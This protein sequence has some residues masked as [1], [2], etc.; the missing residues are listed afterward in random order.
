VE[1][2]MKSVLILGAGFAGLELATALSEEVA[3][4]V[5]VTVIDQSD[6][7]VFGFSKLD[8]MFGRAEPRS[9][10]LAYS[11]LDKPAVAF[12][13][14]RVLSI[15]AANRRVT[16]DAGSYEPDIL[17]V[18]LGA[19][20]DPAATPGLLE[21]G[22]E[23]YSVSGA[24]RVRSILPDFPG[25]DVIISVLGPFF[26]CPAA[27]FE[28]ALMMH[29]YL[30]RRGRL[31]DSTIKVISPMAM[32]IPISPEASAGILKALEERD[33]GWWPQS[34][35]TT[36]DP[37][38]KTALLDDGRTTG[39]DLFL[40][41][42]VHR[43]PQVVEE[44]DLVEDGWIPVDHTTFATRFENVYA[45]GDVT[46]APVPRVGVIAEGEA[47]TLA[48][49][50]IHQIRGGDPPPPYQGVVTCYIEFGDTRV[51]R[52]DANF[53]SGPSPVAW[54][55]EASEHQATSKK[56]WAASRRLRWF[57]IRD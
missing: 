44:S 25:G 38:A 17:V 49:V 1:V 46:S 32:P 28:T 52:F 5:E 12:R 54:F 43:A 50:L 8:V 21:G 24:E 34:T 56:E 36:I 3:E 39:Y 23:Y 29:N 15:D 51:A 48:E 47:K 22:S 6:S 37:V 20:L 35:I 4:D 26:K 45:V 16:T 40:G 30:E 11:R 55:T 33:I 18:A 2:A 31:S 53:F 14:E 41:V 13:Q 9:V 19:D 57:G 10:H 42:P 27:P 7:F